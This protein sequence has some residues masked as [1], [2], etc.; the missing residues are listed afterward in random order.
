[1]GAPVT[2]GAV[3]RTEVEYLDG[4]YGVLCDSW[5]GESNCALLSRLWAGMTRFLMEDHPLMTALG[6]QHGGRYSTMA[7]AWVSAGMGAFGRAVWVRGRRRKRQSLG[8]SEES[9]GRR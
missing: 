1:M 6:L 4:K 7:S 5:E 8:R 3:R 2:I 9:P